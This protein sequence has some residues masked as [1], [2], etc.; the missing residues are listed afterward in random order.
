MGVP[1]SSYSA[2]LVPWPL[3]V[4]AMRAAPIHGNMRLC[5]TGCYH[6]PPPPQR[7]SALPV[8]FFDNLDSKRRVHSLSQRDRHTTAKPCSNAA[9]RLASALTQP[10]PWIITCEHGRASC[11]CAC[12]CACA[13]VRVCVCRVRACVRVHV[14]ACGR[15]QQQ[16]SRPHGWGQTN[17][18]AERSCTSLY[19]GRGRSACR[20]GAGRRPWPLAAS[21]LLRCPRTE[22]SKSDS[23]PVMASS[24]TTAR[25]PSGRTTF[26]SP[27]AC[28][29]LCVRVRV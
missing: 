14:C 17:R 22:G 12:A 20:P 9:Q 11:A 24:S 16:H 26:T 18:R 8:L 7:C 23:T 4:P 21:S 25:R 1:R 19:G 29:R 28:V 27:G 13:C 3:S 6:P 15:V 10:T 2:R 5:R